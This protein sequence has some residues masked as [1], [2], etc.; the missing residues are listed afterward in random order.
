[1]TALYWTL[2][3]LIYILIIVAIARVLRGGGE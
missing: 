3:G 1:M 2:A